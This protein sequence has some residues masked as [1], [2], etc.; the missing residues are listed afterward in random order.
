MNDLDLNSLLGAEDDEGRTR[1]AR[2]RSRRKRKRRSRGRFIAP[3]LAFIVLAGI[4]GG[5]GYYG[6]MWINDTLTPDDFTGRGEGVVLV[7]IKD[8][9]S[10]TEVAQELE[11]LGVVASARAFTNAIDNARKSGS[12]QPGQYRLRKKMAAAEAVSLLDPGNRVLDRTTIPEGWR[13]SDVIPKLAKDTGMPAKELL[14][15]AKDADE[16]GLPS[17]AKGRL[18]GFAFPATYEFQPN[19]TPA[20][21][22]AKMVGRFDE[23]AE[24]LDLVSGAKAL[25]RTPYEIVTIA[26]IVQAEAGRP[27]DMPKIARVIYNRLAHQP[28][29]KLKM[30]STVFYGLGEKG[31][32]ATF[33]QLQSKSKY[34][35]YMYYGLPPGPISNPGDHALKAALHPAKGDWLFFVATDPKSNVTKFATTD[36]EFQK[37]LDEYR[38]N[39]G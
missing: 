38:A 6:Y 27:E 20:Q 35:T 29:M 3:L 25:R 18:E 10:A 28:E 32:A 24:E 12:L 1:R 19:T 4:I 7:E 39:G 14:A 30:D 8:G 22:L 26:S 17:Y 11:R 16:L 23:T 36:A 34:N 9:Q 2:G 15:A 5:G 31:T 37:L 33:A 13:L 21:L